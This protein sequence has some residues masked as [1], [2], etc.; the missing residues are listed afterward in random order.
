MLSF[1]SEKS[2]LQVAGQ[3][4]KWQVKFTSDRWYL[5]VTGQIY[6][7][8]I[9]YTSDI[10]HLKVTGQIYKWQ[11]TFTSLFYLRVTFMIHSSRLKLMTTKNMLKDVINF[12]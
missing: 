3:I 1:I 10:L 12:R 9:K 7:W 6:K 4:Y 11:I 5:Q 2:H 8:Q